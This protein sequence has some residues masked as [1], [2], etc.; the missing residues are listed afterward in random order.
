MNPNIVEI[1]KATQ[2]PNNDP[3]K[4]GRKPSLKNQLKKVGLSDGWL[5]FKKEDVIIE[6]DVIKVRVPKEESLAL[7]LFEI[8][9]GKNPNAAMSAIKMYYEAFDGKAV[10]IQNNLQ[11]NNYEG[12]TSSELREELKRLRTK[13]DGNA[14]TE[15]LEIIRDKNG[16]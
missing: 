10:N 11:I 5:T 7:K 15:D 6:E 3:T 13:F 14:G 8:A 9:M 1:G 4:G 16:S 12:H 2:F